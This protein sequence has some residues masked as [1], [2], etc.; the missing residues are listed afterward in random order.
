MV[1]LGKAA[2]STYQTKGTDTT[3]MQ[4]LGIAGSGALTGLSWMAN[5]RLGQGF[6]NIAKDS[7]ALGVKNVVSGIMKEMTTSTFWKESLKRGLSIKDAA[8]KININ[9]LMNYLTSAFSTAGTLTPY[10][11]GEEQFDKTAAVKILST[12]VTY[13]GL[14]VVEDIFRDY[15]GDYTISDEK[16][17]ELASRIIN[18]E[19]DMRAIQNSGLSQNSIARIS[20]EVIKR[21]I[22][23][24]SFLIIFSFIYY[25][26][27]KNTSAKLS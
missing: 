14:N 5:G 20:E 27:S 22:A 8:G 24:K 9:A 7:A 21:D 2:E 12:Y 25:C 11:T 19:V 17:T 26:H 18:N 10:I 4:E 23:T 3:F 15:I 13:L 6:V 16:A 1:G